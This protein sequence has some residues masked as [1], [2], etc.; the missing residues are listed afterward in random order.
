MDRS[1]E[2]QTRVEAQREELIARYP[3][4][5]AGVMADWQPPGLDD[6]AWLTYSANYL[7]R[8]GGVHWALDPLTL[9]GRLGKSPQENLAAD[10][11]PL[12]FVLLSHRHRDHL[13][14][15]L[16][17][18]LR[19]L[20][21]RWVVPE[22]MQVEVR[23][24]TGL[25][26]RKIITP[27]MG[28]ELVIDGIRILPFEGNHWEILADG[29]SKGVPAMGYRVGFSNKSWLFPGDTR[30]YNPM[31]TPG[32]EPVDGVFA[33]VWLGRGGALLEKPPLLDDFC[34]FQLGF[35]PKRILLTHLHEV[36]REG[37][38]F[39]DERH[40]EILKERMRELAPGVRVEAAFT[41]EA[42]SL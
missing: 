31:Q 1:P 8:T 3:A 2:V 6:R 28:E 17:A 11:E 29:T 19:D 7:F 42:I 34:K 12:S 33:H 36:G 16:I 26:G 13:D 37:E 27:R 20:P 25:P 5:W 23:Q 38:E 14:F 21:M 15:G 18:A 4:L 10:L 39:W 22:W 41:G 35:Q 9:S 32:S 30:S 24:R 40:A